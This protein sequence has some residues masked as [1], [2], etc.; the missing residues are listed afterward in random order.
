MTGSAGSTSGR[1]AEKVLLEGGDTVLECKSDQ[2]GNI[3]DIKFQHQP[4][5]IGFNAFGRDI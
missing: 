4:A 3:A 1:V 5:A 2:V